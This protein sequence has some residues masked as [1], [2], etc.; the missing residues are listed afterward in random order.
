MADCNFENRAGD[1]RTKA[2]FER[3][4]AE[5]LT[6]REV[7]RCLK[8]YV[9]REVFIAISPPEHGTAHRSVGRPE[10]FNRTLLE[11][12]AYKELFLTNAARSAALAPWMDSYN[13]HRPHAAIAGL[14]PLQRL[15]N[16]AD[17]N[18]N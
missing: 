2:Y 10:R 16:N 11:E 3:R 17:G 15:I 5:G 6:N 1:P 8:R 13:A 12:F 4:V 18:H 14:T 7:I 9:V